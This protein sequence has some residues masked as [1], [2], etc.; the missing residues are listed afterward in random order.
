MPILGGGVFS[1]F[2]DPKDTVYADRQ[3]G[4]FEK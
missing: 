4:G 1:I 2:T 3:Y